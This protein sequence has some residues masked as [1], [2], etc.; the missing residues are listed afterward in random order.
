MAG[1][2]KIFL[3]ITVVMYITE[4]DKKCLTFINPEK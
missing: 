1:N 2:S 3:N 4:W